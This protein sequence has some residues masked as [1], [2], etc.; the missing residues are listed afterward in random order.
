MSGFKLA[1]GARA[2]VTAG[3]RARKW[4]KRAAVREVTIA[5]LLPRPVLWT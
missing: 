3:G 1:V 5:A 2:G 4:R